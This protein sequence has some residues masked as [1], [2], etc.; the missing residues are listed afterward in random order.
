MSKASATVGSF[1]TVDSYCVELDKDHLNMVKYQSS[2]D[3]DYRLVL[4]L[5]CRLRKSNNWTKPVEAQLIQAQSE[6]FIGRILYYLY[7]TG[8]QAFNDHSQYVA[9]SLATNVT[10]HLPGRAIFPCCLVDG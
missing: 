8:G 4:D 10:S 3:P 5:V 1:G 9:H 6:F 2:E 7:S